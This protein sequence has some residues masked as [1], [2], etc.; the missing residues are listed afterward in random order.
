PA[1]DGRQRLFPARAARGASA[2]RGPTAQ[3]THVND[4]ARSFDRTY[5]WIDDHHDTTTRGAAAGV[6]APPAGPADAA[7]HAGR[8]GPVGRLALRRG[9]GRAGRAGAGRAR[10]GGWTCPTGAAAAD[11]TEP[12]S[13]PIR[14][15]GLPARPVRGAARTP[16]GGAGGL[17]ER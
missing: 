2:S 9:A 13:A 16:R 8:V 12:S 7:V 6:A 1:P 4:I 11:R 10:D 17:G 5:V 14:R 3:G 15:G